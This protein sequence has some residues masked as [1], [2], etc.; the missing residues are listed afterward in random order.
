LTRAYKLTLPWELNFLIILA[1]FLEIAGGVFGWY[2]RFDQFYYDKITHL[3]SFGTIAVFGMISVIILDVYTEIK[4]NRPMIFF[5]IIIFTLAMG[6]IWEFFEFGIDFY[7]ERGV[8]CGVIQQKNNLDTM[9]DLF[10]DF[11]GGI[12]AAIVGDFYLKH[13]PREKFIQTYLND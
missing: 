7:C 12:I 3:V 13:A 6:V 2:D 10:A 1:L 8:A 11:F 5:L 4:L 9:T